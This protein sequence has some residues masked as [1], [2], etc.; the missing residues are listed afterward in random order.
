MCLLPLFHIIRGKSAAAYIF[1][2]SCHLIN[3]SRYVNIISLRVLP[4][5]LLSPVRAAMFSFHYRPYELEDGWMGNSATLI[6]IRDALNSV[7]ASIKKYVAVRLLNFMTATKLVFVHEQ[8]VTGAFST[9]IPFK[10]VRESNLTSMA[11]T[12]FDQEIL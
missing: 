6:M 10:E 3:H 11:S 9:L 5:I 2:W 7:D 1:A 8:R 12:L 4:Q